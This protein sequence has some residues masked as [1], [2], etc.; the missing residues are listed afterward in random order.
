M[1]TCPCCGQP[2]T[3]AVALTTVEWFVPPTLA[4]VIRTLER[5]GGGPLHIDALAGGVWKYDHAR[6][7]N[8]HECVRN[9]IRRGRDDMK[10]LGWDVVN[11]PHAHGFALVRHED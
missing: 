5:A 9:A 3:C 6:P 10:L 8:A 1:Q 4:Q 11:I 7:V 2:I